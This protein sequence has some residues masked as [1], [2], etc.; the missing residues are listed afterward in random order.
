ML[1]SVLQGFIRLGLHIFCGNITV[2]NEAVLNSKGPLLLASNHP[3]SFLDAIIIG[4]LFKQP[5]HYLARGDAFKQPF[6]RKI[7]CSLKLMPIYRLS[8]GRE[9][10][11]LNDNTF[12]NCKN[13]LLQGGIILIFSE[14]LCKQ[15]WQLQ[16]L[17]KGTARI[18]FT[19]WNEQSIS[20]YFRV[21]PVSI[22]YHSFTQF[23]K[24]V[25]I[26]FG[27]IISK[28]IV[29]LN[30]N[31]GERIQQFNTLLNERLNSGMLLANNNEN[32]VQTLIAKH[33]QI[34]HSPAT[35]IADL[36][37][38]QANIQPSNFPKTSHLLLKA[39]LLLP[40]IVGF[41]LHAV[42]YFPI[43][44][45]VKQKTNGTVFYDSVLFGIL[46]IIYP[47]Y[48]LLVN[49]LVFKSTDIIVLQ[50]V[51]A[52]MPLWLWLLSSFKKLIY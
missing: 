17:K 37:H 32:V 31:E 50:I 29:H 7:L 34:I 35:A 49:I 41:V 21:Q 9:Y 43:K 5:V 45:L 30:A 11:A 2:S 28:Q 26:H 19:A 40:A 25:V 51:S 8:E 20:N 14:G 38:L 23:G 13:I 18:A 1:Y 52:L 39:L 15:K 6:V 4:S 24:Q 12:D 42:L 36:K 16:P 47:F 33:K 3:N 44:K 22:N 27:E 48:Y 46:L 10:L